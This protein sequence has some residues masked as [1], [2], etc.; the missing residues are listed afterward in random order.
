MA[1]LCA[2]QSV[3]EQG[4]QRMIIGTALMGAIGACLRFYVGQ[5]AV[6]RQASRFPFSTL[7]I[8]VLG[9]ALLG[10][11]WGL[12]EQLLIN[13]WVWQWLGV[14]LLGAFTTF[15]TFSYELLQL[16]Q[17]K[18]IGAASAYILATVIL[19]VVAAAVF[20]AAVLFL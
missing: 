2:W 20:R 7:V 8:N 16:I 6:W 11:L 4:G 18:R 10:A 19:G 13:E 3:E 15:S 9:S 14:G 1:W 5:L 12:Y 17:Q